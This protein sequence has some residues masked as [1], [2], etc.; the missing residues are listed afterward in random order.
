MTTTP[1]VDLEPGRGGVDVC[2]L[3]S[4]G[5][6]ADG[7]GR[8]EHPPGVGRAVLAALALGGVRGLS[9]RRL[10]AVVWDEDSLGRQTSTPSTAIHRVRR[11]LDGV[12]KG[13][14]GIRLTA[15]GYAL[16]LDGGEID[17]SRFRALVRRAQAADHQART[18]LLADA[19][20]LWRGPALADVPPERADAAEVAALERE[21]VTASVLYA[22]TLLET[23]DPESAGRVLM[24]LARA[25][26]LDERVLATWMEALAATGRQAEA[27][28][29]YEEFRVRLREELGADPGRELDAVFVAVL[30]GETFASPALR[31]ATRAE[32][33][34]VSP[35][36]GQ[37]VLRP[38]PPPLPIPAEL[39][40]DVT[41]FTGR[42][43]EL[44][45]LDRWL[46]GEDGTGHTAGGRG[47]VCAI[48][49]AGGVGKT[50]LAVHWAHRNVGRFPDGQLFA[51]LRSYSPGQPVRPVDVLAR[52]LASLDVPGK[53][54]PADTDE[55]AG[56][57]RSVLAGKR[58][59]VMLDN[60]ADTG[61]VLPL[62]PA[63]AGCRVIVTSRDRLDGLVA[64]AGA[65]RI[66]LNVLSPD[67]AA[68]LLAEIIGA[69]RAAAKPE[70]V[71]AL[72]AACGYLPLALRIT[73]AHLLAH[74]QRTLTD[75]LEQ[76]HKIGRLAALTLPGEPQASIRTTFEMS[77]QRLDPGARRL[78]R[79]IGLAPGADFT[80]AA[81][82][83]LT[84]TGE[85]EA[86]GLLDR[87]AAAHLLTEHA[88]GRYGCHDLVRGYASERAT[89]EESDSERA[90]AVNRLSEWYLATAD[91]ASRQLYPNA[92]RLPASPAANGS[93][94]AFRSDAAA[95][96]WL[97]AEMPN[98]VATVLAAAEGGP[99]PLAWQ[100]ADALCVFL[101]YSAAGVELLR[102][103]DAGLAA[104]TVAGEVAG[105]A[106]TAHARAM[107]NRI[108]CRRT[109]ERRDCE[110]AVAWSREAGLADREATVLISSLA[111]NLAEG[112][113][114]ERA[115]RLLGEGLRIHRRLGSA[116][117]MAS[118]CTNL[119]LICVEQ[120]SLD[121]AL[122]WNRQ[123]LAL[124]REHKLRQQ[125]GTALNHLANIHRQ[126]GEIAQARAVLD[127]ARALTADIGAAFTGLIVMSTLA[128]L[129][130]DVG[131]YRQ[132]AEAARAILTHRAVGGAPHARGVAHIVLGNVSRRRGRHRDAARD[133]E[134]AIEGAEQAG[135]TRLAVEARIGLAIACQRLGQQDRALSHA[136]QAVADARAGGYRWRE[137]NALTGLAEIHLAQ[138]RPT[139]AARCAR[140]ARDIYLNMG[141]L[142]G[143]ANALQVLGDA[144]L[145]TGDREDALGDLRQAAA[146]FAAIRASDQEGC[147]R[148][149]ADPADGVGAAPGPRGP[150]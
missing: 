43:S 95:V 121:K 104:A 74:R 108:L 111:P 25:H 60:V 37:P 126:K 18:R 23:G 120:G 5:V 67:K 97:D 101:W 17:A 106:A 20:A 143:A 7:T 134:Q 150:V 13:A 51:D 6:R 61:Q 34:S 116:F 57:F 24:P 30:R 41:P 149:G 3:G 100:L 21:R 88:P 10:A 112:G 53:R 99:R 102:I 132:A 52:F 93:A 138:N 72:A 78:F 8:F 122:G 1:A 19:L 75:H 77:Y 2:V 49:G 73:A 82:A 81:A 22:R 36:A 107:A 56:L 119:T 103:A 63:A 28:T 113:E 91:A 85:A 14:V 142:L 40:A 32:H 42:D 39:P 46:R 129:E 84:G 44:A 94:G 55:A 144:G 80:T 146:I 29:A 139:D 50:S 109:D 87:L 125:Q 110:R 27:L 26:P 45:E 12:A 54:I 141:Y 127:E 62:I 86:T 98:L 128:E 58:V 71:T 90:R 11:W 124:A 135:I 9:T 76:L 130:C 70:A 69:E 68:D 16:E 38:A 145:R 105:Q 115:A 4:V 140:R 89:A 59:L 31:A 147:E 137:G 79:L 47:Q 136:R 114:M 92:I 83:A 66:G 148:L 48:V 15:D 117:G 131:R 123:A 35:A 64:V 33:D 96:S 118:A 65:G 133:F